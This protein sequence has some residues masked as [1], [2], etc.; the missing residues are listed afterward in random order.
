MNKSC[1]V[2]LVS[3]YAYHEESV[4]RAEVARAMCR[5]YPQDGQ[6]HGFH[7]ENYI[8]CDGTQLRLMDCDIGSEQYSESEYYVWPPGIKSTQLLFIFPTRVNVTTITLYYY[9]DSLPGLKFYAV[10]DDF[11]IW[12]ALT[13]SYRY[14]E[15]A[16]QPTV[17]EPAVHKNISIHFNFKTKKVVLQ[18]LASLYK[19]A[20]SELEFYTCNSEWY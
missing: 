5:N 6:L 1:Q 19:F 4:T 17:G 8:H 14:V 13:F 20:A 12:Q 3:E 15:I 11:E 2:N 18:K 16:A 9:S 7:P 10:P